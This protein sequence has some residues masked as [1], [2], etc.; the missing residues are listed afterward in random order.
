MWQPNC[1][2]QCRVC[3]ND[4]SPPKNHGLSYGNWERG[5]LE[6]TEP[7]HTVI[8]PDLLLHPDHYVFI[9]PHPPRISRR[10]HRA[11]GSGTARLEWGTHM[12][13]T[14]NQERH[15]FISSVMSSTMFCSSNDM[16]TS[17]RS[18][19]HARI[20]L[21]LCHPSTT[22]FIDATGLGELGLGSGP[23]GTIK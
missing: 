3:Q 18:R 23:G 21:T 2:H 12:E 7:R 6:R 15:P 22:M 5:T 17:I 10:A 11:S 1:T 9:H 19:E 20:R 8:H 14:G 13:G 4:D 16:G